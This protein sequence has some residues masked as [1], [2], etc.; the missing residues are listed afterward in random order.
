MAE[1]NEREENSKKDRE[2]LIKRRIA[3]IVVAMILGAIAGFVIMR[4]LYR[5]ELLCFLYD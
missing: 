5:A 3:V 2:N 4:T 1:K